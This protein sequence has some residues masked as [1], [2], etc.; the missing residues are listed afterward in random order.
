MFRKVFNNKVFVNFRFLSM[1]STRPKSY[2]IVVIEELRL[3][4]VMLFAYV[5]IVYM[6]AFLRIC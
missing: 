3:V 4:N 1:Q 2:Y 5:F 6:I